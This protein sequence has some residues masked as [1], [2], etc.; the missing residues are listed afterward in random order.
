VERDKHC[1]RCYVEPLPNQ[2]VIEL[3]STFAK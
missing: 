1:I 2:T 3:S